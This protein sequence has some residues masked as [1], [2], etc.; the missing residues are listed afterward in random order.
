MFK[1]LATFRVAK[2]CGFRHWD[3]LLPTGAD[4]ILEQ[5]LTQEGYEM[6]EEPVN[7]IDP[8]ISGL[9]L[10]CIPVLGLFAFVNLMIFRN[11]VLRLYVIPCLGEDFKFTDWQQLIFTVVPEL[12]YYY[13]YKN[14]RMEK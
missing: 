5:L 2:E 4:Y 1:R 7:I 14:W 9:I 10:S 3:V 8:T 13:I 6:D 12:F 11:R